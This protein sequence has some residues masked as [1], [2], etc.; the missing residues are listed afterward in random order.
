MRVFREEGLGVLQR[1]WERRFRK[2]PE[3]SFAWRL[4]YYH[5]HPQYRT[6]AYYRLREAAAAV[7]IRGIFARLYERASRRSGL[8][9]HCPRLAGGV[10]MPHWGRIL[11]NASEIGEDL[12]VFH[13]VTVGND[14]RTGIPKIGKSV[15]IGAGAMILGKVVIGDGVV[16][17]AGSVVLDDVPSGSLVAGNPA[18]VIR[19]VTDEYRRELVK[20]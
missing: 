15:F 12:Y 10:L 19:A 20:Y 16:V 11:L 7:W 17:A 2:H 4:G 8:E 3:T 5:W 13:N 6:L 14:Y 9:I 1:D 18:R